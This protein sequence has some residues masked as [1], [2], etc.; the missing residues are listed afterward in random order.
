[1]LK[2]DATLK[3]MNEGFWGAKAM[4]RRVIACCAENPGCPLGEYCLQHY[5]NFINQRDAPDRTIQPGYKSSIATR[6]RNYHLMRQA[7]VPSRE[8]ARRTTNKQTRLALE[9]AK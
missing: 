7:G 1:M 6:L 9:A 8:A 2:L 3:L 4:E 5:D